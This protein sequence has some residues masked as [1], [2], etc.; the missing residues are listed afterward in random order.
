MRVTSIQI[1]MEDRSKEDAVRQVLGALDRCPASD[2]ILLPEIWTSGFFCF[3]RYESDSEAIDGPVV[4]LF[5]ERAARR[6]CYILMGSIVEREGDRV[7]NTS[8]LLDSKGEIAGKYRKIHL[9]GYR[10]R[11]K[12]ILTPGKEVVVAKTPWGVAGLSTCYD[13]RFPEVYRKML[14]GGATLFL[15]ASA[16][17]RVRL[18]PWRLFNRVRALENLSYLFSCNCAGANAGI[19][20]AGHSMLVDPWGNVLAEGGE[21]ECCVSA[22]VDPTLVQQV[23]REFS[24]VDDRVPI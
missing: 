24:A 6:G 16:W 19:E 7:Y 15:V 20:Y 10:S 4:T 5:R 23:R 22:E 12:A 14:D 1:A 21:D 18:D 3:D 17:P 11:E 13:L 2:L 9:F 8:V